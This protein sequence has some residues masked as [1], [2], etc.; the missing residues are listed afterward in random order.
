MMRI[1]VFM[2][3]WGPAPGWEKQFIQ[4]AADIPV[5]QFVLVGD[6]AQWVRDADLPR[7][8]CTMD[9]FEQ[10]ASRIS[11]VRIRKNHPGY[12]R[13]QALCELRPLMA[14]MYPD[15]VAAAEWWGWGEWDCVLGDW[16]SF[17][18]PEVL[19]NFDAVS[20]ASYTINGPFTIWRNRE[21]LRKLYRNRLDI[22]Q[23]DDCSEHL[24]EA[25]MQKIVEPLIAAGKIRILYP[26]DLDS[27]DR[28]D[29][30]SRCT[31]MDGKLYR[32]DDLG[33]IGN[34]LLNFHFQG[35]SQWP[36]VLSAL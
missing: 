6:A 9:E 33:N 19:D 29:R 18:T 26:K 15:I 30:W 36:A 12:C 3:W 4:R 8:F 32:M 7:I 23:R 2:P 27:H 22:L 5:L 16:T 20:S 11:G 28:H 14:E 1:P 35:T 25:G 13:G 24:D 31:I 34:E 21:D 10:I 17:L